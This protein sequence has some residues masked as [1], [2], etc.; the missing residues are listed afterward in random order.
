MKKCFIWGSALVVML[1]MA[2][3]I[4]YRPLVRGGCSLLL[5]RLGVTYEIL[6]WEEDR[7]V[8][9]GLN[10]QGRSQ[11]MSIDQV[12][13]QLHGDWQRGCFSPKIHLVHPQIVIEGISSSASVMPFPFYYSSR[14]QPQISM[15]SGVLQ[16]FSSRFYLRG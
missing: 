6:Q 1:C 16:C 9:R 2:M 10:W 8:V 15:T 3:L 12:Q 5:A 11:E 4:G 7:L 14:I 13:I